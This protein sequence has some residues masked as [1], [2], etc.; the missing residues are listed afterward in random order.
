MIYMV[1]SA[2]KRRPP[3]FFANLRD[4]LALMVRS[5]KNTGS[6]DVQGSDRETLESIDRLLE[7]HGYETSDLVNQYYLDQYRVQREMST[8]PF[9]Q[10]TVRCWF[11]GNTLEI[12]VMNAQ[13]LL[14]MDSNGLCDPFVRIHFMPEDKFTNVSKPKT[15][16]QSKTLHP[17]YDEQFS[18]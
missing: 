6:S 15:N 14:P 1:I 11:S 12:Y 5:F 7:L 13:K 9:G 4:T 2:Q 17:L 10:L 18:M 8:A 16:T 3:S